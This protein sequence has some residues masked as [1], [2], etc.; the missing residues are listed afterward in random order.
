MNLHPMSDFKIEV[1]NILVYYCYEAGNS[2][3]TQH[4]YVGGVKTRTLPNADFIKVS[5]AI[6]AQHM[7]KG[8]DTDSDESEENEPVGQCPTRKFKISHI[9]TGDTQY[10]GRHHLPYFQI[11][12]TGLTTYKELL[13]MCLEWQNTD[14]LDEELFRNSEDYN[15]FRDAINEM[16]SSVENMGAIFCPSLEVPETEE[17]QEYWDVCAFFTVE[18]L[19]EDDAI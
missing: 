13:G 4:F 16:F 11:S 12:V 17:E 7:E 10:F 9:T 14:H 2:L 8:T 15:A 5:N 1:G 6:H 18:V 19:G 3:Q